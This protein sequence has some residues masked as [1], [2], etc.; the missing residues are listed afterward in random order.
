MSDGDLPA[1]ISAPARR[2]LAQAGFS[3]L[4]QIAGV[5]VVDLQR[6]HGMGPKAIGTIRDAL[7]S[8]GMSFADERVSA[9][10]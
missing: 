6:L 7:H 10:Q 2:A 5:R 3:R 8:R 9:T 4:D 1:G